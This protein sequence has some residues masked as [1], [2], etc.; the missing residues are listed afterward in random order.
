MKF[1]SKRNVLLKRLYLQYE[2]GLSELDYL[3]KIYKQVKLQELVKFN[4][5]VYMRSIPKNNKYYKYP[6]HFHVIVKDI[7]SGSAMLEDEDGDLVSTICD[8]KIEIKID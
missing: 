5:K 3:E 4:G 2:N 7:Y 6:Y 1:N 8:Y